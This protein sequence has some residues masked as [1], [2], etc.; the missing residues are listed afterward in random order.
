LATALQAAG[1]RVNLVS[2]R[3]WA[4]ELAAKTDAPTHLFLAVLDPAIGEMASAI[5]GS[6][7][8]DR[9]AAIVHLSGPM[10]LDVLEPARAAGHPVGSFHPFQSFPVE[11]PPEAFR[12]SLIGIDASTPQLYGQ[13]EALA[14]E[15]GGIPRRVP[16]E[17]RTLYHA[18]AVLSSNLLIALSSR[19][20]GVL[21]T[22]G[23]DRDEALAAIVP[24]MKGVVANLETLG[25]PEALIGPI[26]RGDPATV[27]RHL[28]ALEASGN[29]DAAAVYRILGMAALDLALEAGLEAGPGDQ[30][31]KAL[32]AS[33]AATRR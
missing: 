24:L 5:A 2:G 18:A 16:D 20:A 19:A 28:E 9:R 21:E 23:F 8:V 11:R 22:V 7:D 14:Q 30:I 15:M 25:L 29:R 6:S 26:R 17:S 33:P 12:G 31:R 32:T 13:L 10:G 27:R 4:A 3:S 1:H